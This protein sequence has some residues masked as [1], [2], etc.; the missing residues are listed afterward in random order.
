MRVSQSLG[1]TL[2]EAPAEA[3]TASH[4]LMLRASLIYQVAAGVYAYLPLAYRSLKK[5]EQIIREEMDAAGAQEVHM[6]TLQPLELWHK[7]GRDAALGQNPVP[8]SR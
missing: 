7:T 5:L 4:R 8:A 3:E 6:P 1:K 2:R